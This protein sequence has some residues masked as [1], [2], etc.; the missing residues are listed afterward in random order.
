M[1]LKVLRYI[2][3]VWGGIAAC[4][5]HTLCMHHLCFMYAVCIQRA[6]PTGIDKGADGRLREGVWMKN[7]LF[8]V[9]EGRREWGII[10]F[11]F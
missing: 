2:G 4:T 3:K 10:V 7:N 5:R 8:M 11:V 1:K 6:G 9:L